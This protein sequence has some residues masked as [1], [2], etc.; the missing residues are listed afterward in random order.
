MMYVPQPSRGF[1]AATGGQDVTASGALLLQTAPFTGPAAPFVAI[2]GAITEFLGAMG[3]G[4]GCGQTCVLSTQYANQA[5]SY[6]RQ[7]LAAYQAL[8]SPRPLSA[9]TAALANFDTVWADL[10]QQC[11]NPAL[12][13]AGARCISDRQRGSTAYGGWSWFSGYRDPIS[14]DAVYD[15]S[16]AGAASNLVAS[17]GSA[18]GSLGGV[19]LGT[20]AL[21]AIAGLAVWAVAS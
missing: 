16:V 13:D 19:S 4:S 10:V 9:Q 12:G 5:E 15:D 6:L 11:S 17:A 3:V 18:V 21:L 8:P 14:S 20:L 2:A 7:N 1:G